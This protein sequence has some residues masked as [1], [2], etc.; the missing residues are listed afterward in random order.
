MNETRNSGGMTPTDSDGRSF[1]VAP[2][3]I[4]LPKGGG[5][6]RGI[7]D[8]FGVNPV[9]GTATLSI[10]IYTSP[11][12]AGFGPQLTLSYDSGA[13]N[14]PFGFGWSLSL[15][16]ITRK[17]DKGLPRYEDS[18][19]SDVFI[20]SGTEDLVPVVTMQGGQWKPEPVPARTV[21]TKTYDIRRY[22]PRIEGLFARIERWT[23]QTDATDV[24]WRS[25][26]KDNITT[27]YGKTP[28]CRIFDPADRSHIF[29]WLICESYDDKGNAI[30]YVYNE[31][32]DKRLDRSQ[33]C[34]RNRSEKANRYLKRIKYT[35]K[36]PRTFDEDLTTR[37][38][39]LFETVFDYDEN[40]YEDVPLNQAVPAA[41]QH[42]FVLGSIDPG[43][44]WVVRPDPFSTYRAGFEV[45]TYRRCRRVLVFHRFQELGAEPCLVKSTEFE[46][47]DFD[48]AKPFTVEDELNHKG[49]TRIASFIRSVRQ[50]G[51]L[52]DSPPVV[53]QKNGVNYVKYL[54]KS[55]PDVEFD[56]SQAIIDETVRDVDA[57]S[58]ESLPYGVDGGNYQWLDL[59]GEGVSGVLTEQAAAW[60][61]KRNLS[62]G[63]RVF[64]SNEERTEPRFGPVEVVATKPTLAL[65]GGQIQFLDLAGDGQVDLATFAGTSPGFYERTGDEGWGALRSLHVPSQPLLERTESEVRRSHRGRSPGHPHH[66]TRSL[67]LAS[68]ASR[69]RVRTR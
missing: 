18:A 39:W 40:H 5:A 27:W 7:G 42:Q 19:D 55:L 59:D 23:N 9:T 49:S 51:Y 63:N 37:T 45:R 17:T 10:P 3:Q 46:Y 60:F 28:E 58:L 64:Q 16:S 26:S 32:D 14:G 43:T 44:P 8:K 4:S 66:R 47:A 41:D 68:L 30:L 57:D 15:P 12:R 48:Y 54:K 33:S 62:P 61:Y 34:E 38:D 56:Y 11:G 36:T 22:R 25:I 1:S 13:G 2:P 69:R 52:A 6:T 65:A 21:N 53:T 29:S 50:S 24:C 67:C 20:L 35:N 31:E